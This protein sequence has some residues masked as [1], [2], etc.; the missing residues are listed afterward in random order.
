[1]VGAQPWTRPDL[2]VDV[3]RRAALEPPDDLHHLPLG[4]GQGFGGLARHG[5]RP[6][7]VTSPVA[8]LQIS[9]APAPCQRYS[10]E[11]A[12]G[13]LP[14]AG[15]PATIEAGRPRASPSAPIPG[16]LATMIRPI[17]PSRA[18][19]TL[20]GRARL[21]ALAVLLAGRLGDRRTRSASR[22]AGGPS[23]S[24][25]T[26]PTSPSGA[27]ATTWSSPGP[28]RGGPAQA[29]RRPGRPV[30]RRAGPRRSAA[31]ARRS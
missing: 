22:P 24:R 18:G 7:S 11:I 5:H 10:S 19:P 4:D 28:G 29:R 14:I 21:L 1:M 23:S 31:T 20:A 12:P 26:T 16:A 2:L 15:P 25:S 27:T 3:P 30:A 8:R 9:P 13:P 6:E 17:D